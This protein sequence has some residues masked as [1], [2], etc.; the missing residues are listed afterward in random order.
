[1]QVL[2][3]RLFRSQVSLGFHLFSEINAHQIVLFDLELALDGIYE[4][5]QLTA[6]LAVLLRG[7]LNLP[8]RQLHTHL[9]QNLTR[10]LQIDVMRL[11]NHDHSLFSSAALRYGPMLY[12]FVKGRPPAT[13]GITSSP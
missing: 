13:R 11:P 12:S 7:A 1:M 10:L 9:R 4:E 8:E 3:H 2:L 5:G 6:P